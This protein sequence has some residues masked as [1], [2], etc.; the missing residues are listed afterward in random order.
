[1]GD[2]L[3]AVLVFLV[4]AFAFPTRRAPAL[5]AIAFAISLS[6]ELLQ[7]YQSP[8]LNG[9]R[10]TLPGRLLLGQGFLFSDLLCYAIGIAVASIS[11]S[12]AT[13]SGAKEIAIIAAGTLIACIGI[14]ATAHWLGGKHPSTSRN[15]EDGRRC[16]VELRL[17]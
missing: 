10:D 3:W 13:R 14:A 7:L 17:G 8:W 15:V 6:V 12:I 16:A 5:A 4:L 11:Y 2:T 9:V 1:A